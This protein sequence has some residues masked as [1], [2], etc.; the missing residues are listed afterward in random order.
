MSKQFVTALAKGNLNFGVLIYS[1]IYWYLVTLD[2]LFS[3]IVCFIKMVHAQADWIQSFSNKVELLNQQTSHV[4]FDECSFSDPFL[5]AILQSEY[6]NVSQFPL[7]HGMGA[8]VILYEN[9][10]AWISTSTGSTDNSYALLAGIYNTPM[11]NPYDRFEQSLRFFQNALVDDCSDITPRPEDIAHGLSRHAA[12]SD[13]SL[14]HRLSLEIRN[15]L[16]GSSLKKDFPMAFEGLRQIYDWFE[17]DNI[18]VAK[19]NERKIDFQAAVNR[20]NEDAHKFTEMN[21]VSLDSDSNDTNSIAKSLALFSYNSRGQGGGSG[22]GSGRSN[23][24]NPSGEHGGKGRPKRP[25]RQTRQETQQF[26]ETHSKD[27]SSRAY[28]NRDRPSNFENT[29]VSELI[30][31]AMYLYAVLLKI[32]TSSDVHD[33]IQLS[34]ES[35]GRMFDWISLSVD[36]KTLS[37]RT[38]ELKK[39]ARDEVDVTKATSKEEAKKFRKAAASKITTKVSTGPKHASTMIRLKQDEYFSRTLYTVLLKSWDGINQRLRDSVQLLPLNVVLRFLRNNPYLLASARI[40][41]NN[42]VGPQQ[43]FAEDCRKLPGVDDVVSTLHK[44]CSARAV[45]HALF[46]P[47][48]PQPLPSVQQQFDREPNN[49]QRQQQWGPHPGSSSTGDKG[50]TRATQRIVWA[51]YDSET[52]DDYYDDHQADDDG[53]HGAYPGYHDDQRGAPAEQ[54]LNDAWQR[55]EDQA[56]SQADHARKNRRPQKGAR[57]TMSIEQY[58]EL[59]SQP[60][61]TGKQHPTTDPAGSRLPVHTGKPLDISGNSTLQGLFHGDGAGSSH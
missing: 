7:L 25:D 24:S 35:L 26:K 2:A 11:I 60:S 1:D 48:K 28:A 5:S 43:S 14:V 36:D 39:K 10:L 31:N 58:N 21:E 22:R 37:K 33:S 57:V 53:H 52:D 61:R 29:S 13:A 27:P 19:G 46:A 20:F 32:S 44:A 47:T 17:E 41:E 30:K 16:N 8:V 56:R 45:R 55:G 23:R 3:R 40:A 15:V 42:L 50:A 49:R 51:D 4:Q 12:L 6:S 18:R 59:Q 9:C 34:S 54:S 38:E